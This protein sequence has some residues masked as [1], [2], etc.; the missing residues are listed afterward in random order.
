[1]G[2]PAA[3]RV[4]VDDGITLIRRNGSTLWT[5]RIWVRA[6][7]TWRSSGFRTLE[8]AKAWARE[9]RARL[10]LEAAGLAVPVDKRT[11]IP[12]LV[13]EWRAELE[14]RG[15]DAEYAR[16][17]SG[18]VVEVLASFSR[19]DEITPDLLTQALE[20]VAQARRPKP[21]ARKLTAAAPARRGK[22][23]QG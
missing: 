2:R 12:Q 10:E 15:R 11:T 17:A 8:P 22:A 21:D 6:R 7:E 9:L 4:V 20:R 13:G 14:R 5:A 23:R 19:L 1:M 3:R 18:R 16:V